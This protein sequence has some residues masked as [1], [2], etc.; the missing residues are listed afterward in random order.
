MTRQNTL[1]IKSIRRGK[2]WEGI[3]APNT[4]DMSVGVWPITGTS[5]LKGLPNMPPASPAFQLHRWE[6]KIET[7]PEAETLPEISSLLHWQSRKTW[8][9]GSNQLQREF[10]L[11]ATFFALHWRYYYLHEQFCG[12]L[13]FPLCKLWV[14]VERTTCWAR[15]VKFAA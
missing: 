4:Q 5:G 8:E 15:C 6:Y 12:D 3:A 14:V 1:T 2:V 9:L 13:R 11:F 7:P 10:D